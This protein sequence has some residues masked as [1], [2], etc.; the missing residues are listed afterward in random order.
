MTAVVNL[1][2][3]FREVAKLVYQHASTISK[4]QVSLFFRPAVLHLF[5]YLK[6]KP[7]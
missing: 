1:L 3:Y 5:E 4:K 2:S 6:F 7:L